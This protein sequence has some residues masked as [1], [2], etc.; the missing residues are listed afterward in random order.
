MKPLW[1]LP[2]PVVPDRQYS[3]KKAGSRG[4]EKLPGPLPVCSIGKQ[5]EDMPQGI[6]SFLFRHLMEQR[7]AAEAAPL[8]PALRPTTTR[9]RPLR[10]YAPSGR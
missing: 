5:K 10:A 9:L 2:R 8:C 1:E 7:P 3:V 6:P 4:E